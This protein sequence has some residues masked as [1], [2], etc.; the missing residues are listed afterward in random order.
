MLSVNTAEIIKKADEIVRL[1]ETRN[2]R[3]I[4]RE[5]GINIMEY[6]F[7]KQKGAYKVVMKNR[8]VFLKD[9]M[10]PIMTDIV[11]WH[12][13]GHDQFH[14][15]EAIKVGI[16]KEFNIFDMQQNRME[17]EANIFAS[18]G[19][20]D[21]NDVLECVEQGYDV[22]QIARALRSDINLVILKID[23]LIQKG[24]RLRRMDHRN[25]FLKS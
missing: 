3:S 14:R 1:C 17:Y 20:L 10:N 15:D 23:T 13:I 12:E 5:L 4:A 21:D 19:S 24:Y 9:D 22:Y 18:Q 8:Y 16:F 25:D 6:H 11:L 2:P 7:K